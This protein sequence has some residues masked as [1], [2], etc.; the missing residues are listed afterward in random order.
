MSSAKPKQDK[1]PLHGYRILE[2][3]QYIAAP[4]A[5]RLLGDLGADVI[6]IE[7]P[8]GD[9]IRLW[10]EQYNGQ[11]LWWSV[12]ARNKRSITLNLKAEGAKE[13]LAQLIKECDAVVE[14][15]RAGQLARLGF[16]DEF[17][18]AANPDIVIC[19]VSGFGQTGPKAHSAGFGVI[20]EA[21]GGLRYL[22]N[23]PN[24][25]PD[26]PPSRVGISIGDSVAGLYAAL[27]IVASLA[28]K[29]KTTNRVV[30]VALTEAVLS[31]LEGTLPEYGKTG[32]V[33]EP[34][35]GRIPTAAPSNAFPT[36]DKNW[37]LIAANSDKLFASLCTLIG[38]PKL[39]SNPQFLTNVERC[40]NVDALEAMIAAWTIQYDASDVEEKLKS[41]DIPSC[42]VY[43][44]PDIVGDEQFQARDMILSVDDPIVG[45]VLH[46]APVP[47][48]EGQTMKINNT[49]PAIG[50][51][52]EDI[53]RDL[54]KLSGSA[55]EDFKTSGVI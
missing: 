25:G 32:K 37:V 39:S 55:F 12:H 29:D 6:K 38:K 24:P 2:L 14:N 54:L 42:R 43:R 51:H 30:D 23:V 22:T 8:T 46:P 15:F 45:D 28:S 31:V 26:Q 20:G 7:A 35:G 27:G 5:S 17:F 36:H 11:S 52:N 16:S 18:R 3:G 9:P 13:I 48:Y 4:F 41:A 34:A 21:I 40:K 1:G 19:H 10:G 49:G 44:I 53:Y 47:R 50:Q 33:R